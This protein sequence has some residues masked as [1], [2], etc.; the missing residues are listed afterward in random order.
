M[1]QSRVTGIEVTLR[2]RVKR[3]IL[4]KNQKRAVTRII[5]FI[6]TLTSPCCLKTVAAVGRKAVDLSGYVC[7]YIQDENF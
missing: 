3:L 4:H 7:C 6:L 1:E 5:M 2:I